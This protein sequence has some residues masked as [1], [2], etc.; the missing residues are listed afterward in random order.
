MRK[1]QVLAD[2]QQVILKTLLEEPF[3]ENETSAT[4]KAKMFYKSCMDI[5]KSLYIII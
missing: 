2:E 5:R 3:T 1:M 4:R